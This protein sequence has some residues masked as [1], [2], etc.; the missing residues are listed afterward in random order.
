MML[1]SRTWHEYGWRPP[2]VFTPVWRMLK[3]GAAAGLDAQSGQSSNWI[4]DQWPIK[5]RGLFRLDDPRPLPEGYPVA[6][7]EGLP[8]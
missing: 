2:G 8:A 1:G 4:C 5:V 6:L 3:A 7:A